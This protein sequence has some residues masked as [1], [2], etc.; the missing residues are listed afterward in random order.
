[1]QKNA[2]CNLVY[3]AKEL[4]KQNRKSDFKKNFS[5]LTLFSKVKSFNNKQAIAKNNHAIL[6]YKPQKA[7]DRKKGSIKKIEAINRQSKK[8]I[9]FRHCFKIKAYPKKI[10]KDNNVFEN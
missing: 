10:K 8:S 9:F 2:N 3:K 5:L 7:V 1:M 6:S 4:N